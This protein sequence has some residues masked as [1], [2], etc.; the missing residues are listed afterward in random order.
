[1]QRL[2]GNKFAEMKPNLKIVSFEKSEKGHI[3]VNLRL[4]TA[5]CR[6]ATYFH[7]LNPTEQKTFEN[8]DYYKNKMKEL[9]K[10]PRP[11]NHLITFEISTNPYGDRLYNRKYFEFRPGV[12]ILVGR[13]GVGKTTLLDM[14]E[15]RCQR[16]N[17]PCYYYNDR[18]DNFR[19]LEQA[20]D[21]GDFSKISMLSFHS[22][23]EKIY[24]NL[25]YRVSDIKR[26]IDGHQN[27]KKV[28]LLFDSIESGLD[29][30][31]VEQIKN[32]FNFILQDRADKDTYIL[33][34]AQNY[35][36]MENEQCFDVAKG[37][38]VSIDSFETLKSFIHQQCE[39]ASRKTRE[40]MKDEKRKAI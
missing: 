37:C 6:K 38:Y 20:V 21:R 22:E 19:D 7:W 30:D 31:G 25:C 11:D 34:S 16:N 17:I 33:V 26:F 2:Q 3:R 5:K 35:A 29:T 32:I 4:K 18:R 13:N 40:M 23:G 36:M 10:T 8:S 28:M 9:N 1:M 15:R 39:K 24:N 27:S 12:S 14:L